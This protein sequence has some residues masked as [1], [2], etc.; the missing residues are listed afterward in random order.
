MWCWSTNHFQS[1]VPKVS[2]SRDMQKPTLCT[3]WRSLTTLWRQMWTRIRSQWYP[4]S[5]LCLECL[6]NTGIPNL[7]LI[8]RHRPM[9]PF[10]RSSNVCFSSLSDDLSIQIAWARTWCC[11]SIATFIVF[12][13]CCTFA[14][15]LYHIAIKRI[16][17]VQHSYRVRS[18]SKY[19]KVEESLSLTFIFH[20]CNRNHSPEWT[21]YSTHTE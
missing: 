11:T 4:S 19:Q 21:V 14:L 20:F 6:L 12:N 10:K 8:I 13:S 9:C 5:G 18:V 3:P 7:E 15:D 1:H 2:F 16:T 17:V